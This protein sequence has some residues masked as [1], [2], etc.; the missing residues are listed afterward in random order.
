MDGRTTA[1]FVIYLMQIYEAANLLHVG[2]VCGGA[3]QTAMKLQPIQTNWLVREGVGQGVCQFF[4]NV[5][6]KKRSL[7]RDFRILNS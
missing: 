6:T 2:G 7:G 4:G 1:P 5:S 3:L